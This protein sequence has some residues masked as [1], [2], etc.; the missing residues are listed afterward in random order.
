MDRDDI[1]E[2]LKNIN[3][4]RGERANEAFERGDTERGFELAGFAE[5]CGEAAQALE[6]GQSLAE[7]NDRWNG[8]LD[9]L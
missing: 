4:T 7:V 1:I 6:S 2:M 9:A 3:R 5:A 8:I